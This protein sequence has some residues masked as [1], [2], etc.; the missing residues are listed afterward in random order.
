MVPSQDVQS[1]DITPQYGITATPAFDPTTDTIY[2]V[3]F[4]KEIVKN[5]AHYVQRLHAVDA[6]TGD[7]KFGGP[8]V[9]G[10]TTKIK[11]VY[12][13]NT[14][15]YV[16]GT[17]DGNDGQ[18]HVYFNALREG[19]RSALTL[20][21]GQLYIAW[22]SHGDNGPYHGWI[23]AYNPTT[24]ALTGV[25]NTTPNGSEGG[26]WMSQGKL[27]VDDQ[28]NLYAETGNGTFDGSN[29]TGVVTG[30]DAN[31]FPVLGDYGD[32]FLKIG[33][34]NVHDSPTNQNIN[35][36]GLQVVDYFTPYNQATL[37]SGD[38]DLGSAP[39]LVARF[40]RRRGPSAAPGGI[41]QARNHL[42]SRSESDGE[43]QRQPGRRAC[44]RRPGNTERAHGS[45]R[46][47][48]VLQPAAL[49]CG[50]GNEDGN[51]FLLAGRDGEIGPDPDL[52]IG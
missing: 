12:T 29:A 23:V 15:I 19:L 16:N 32:S 43:V 38:L 22:A 39:L 45:L 3:T 7:E 36:W 9:I 10:D 28:G 46:Y 49:L 20:A 21:N 41:G 26:I 17:G 42:P 24:L 18:G 13:N 37:D 30:L 5:V 52:R 40:I 8:V 33:V 2:V 14:Q 27:A 44:G 25:L 1:T 35:G 48:G 50:G 4:T 31:G 47:A 34:D 6:F 11:G 51:D